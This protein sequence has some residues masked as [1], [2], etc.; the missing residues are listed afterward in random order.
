MGKLD[1]AAQ[2]AKAHGPVAIMGEQAAARPKPGRSPAELSELVQPDFRPT[3]TWSAPT[4]TQAP[5]AG[6]TKLEDVPAF[7]AASAADQA[8]LKAAFAKASPSDRAQLLAIVKSPAYAGASPE[9]KHLIDTL[10]LSLLNKPLRTDRDAVGAQAPKTALEALANAVN[11]QQDGKSK[12]FDVG[13]DGK[14]ALEQLSRLTSEKIDPGLAARIA[15]RNASDFLIGLLQ[16]VANPGRVEQGSSGTCSVTTLQALT[17][18]RS[19]GE[20]VRLCVGLAIDGEVKTKSGDVVKLNVA[21][22]PKTDAYQRTVSECVFQGSLMQAVGGDRYVD[23]GDG[24]GGF[25]G[26]DGTVVD[27]LTDAMWARAAEMLTN[28]S[29]E[30]VTPGQDLLA[31]LHAMNASERFDDRGVFVEFKEFRPDMADSGHALQLVAVD[32]STTPPCLV[33]RNP[34]GPTTRAKDGDPLVHGP[35]G[36]T[37]RDTK[38]GLIAVPLTPENLAVIG[39]VMRPAGSLAHRGA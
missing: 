16:E 25:V 33:C 5:P 9:A 31:M 35:R 32:R 8:A 23:D 37:W 13:A 22:V 34:W 2:P 1:A 7:S 21:G 17:A 4:L 38:E 18:L 39:D 26:K 11:A 6:A 3:V 15:P 28:Q 30:R 20:Y 27:G 36:A 14:T 29:Y 24:K 19:P 12:L 10:A